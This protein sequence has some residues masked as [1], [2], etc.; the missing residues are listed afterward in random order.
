MQIIVSPEV[1]Y[2]LA[3]GATF[4]LPLLALAAI[5]RSWKA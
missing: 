4:A 3:V 5:V 2:L 1:L